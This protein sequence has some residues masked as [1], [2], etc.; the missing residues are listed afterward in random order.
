MRF[1]EMQA[2]R[3]RAEPLQVSAENT[4]MAPQTQLVLELG[5]HKS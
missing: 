2:E 5:Q 1:P 3:H 4:N